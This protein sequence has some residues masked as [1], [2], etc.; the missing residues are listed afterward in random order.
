ML[1][2]VTLKIVSLYQEVFITFLKYYSSQAIKCSDWLCW[3]KTAKY[4]IDN[5]I[6]ITVVKTFMSSVETTFDIGETSFMFRKKKIRHPQSGL[7]RD[8]F[9]NQPKLYIC[10]LKWSYKLWPLLQ[11]IFNMSISTSIWKSYRC[12]FKCLYVSLYLRV[13]RNK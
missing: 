6:F 9:Q 12:Y 1:V 8:S 5:K 11:I 7:K 4:S 2:Y 3:N 13:F 10:F